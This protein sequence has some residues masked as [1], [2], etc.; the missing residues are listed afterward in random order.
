MKQ[1]ISAIPTMEEFFN[2]SNDESFT[3]V[4]RNGDGSSGTGCTPDG[5]EVAFWC[6]QNASGKYYTFGKTHVAFEKEEDASRFKDWDFDREIPKQNKSGTPWPDASDFA[7]DCATEPVTLIGNQSPSIRLVDDYGNPTTNG[8]AFWLWSR[9][10]LSER[11]YFWNNRVYF[12]NEQDAIVGS[13]YLEK[14]PGSDSL[15]FGLSEGPYPRS[16]RKRQFDDSL[17]IWSSPIASGHTLSVSSGGTGA[18]SVSGN[19]NVTG[20]L[21]CSTLTA[22]SLQVGSIELED[23]EDGDDE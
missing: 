23:D 7:E 4:S 13:L 8:L 15:E 14:M 12:S 20:T 5:M 19:M 16:Y 18:T 21:T 11:V 6:I 10:N 1:P 2:D 17:A 22:K 9:E 3:V